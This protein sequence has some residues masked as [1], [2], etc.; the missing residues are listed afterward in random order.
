M[1]AKKDEVGEWWSVG[2]A[3]GYR[4]LNAA[5]RTRNFVLTKLP[6]WLFHV[7]ME[8]GSVSTDIKTGC[9]VTL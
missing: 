9:L 8:C 1:P 2:F 7:M 5:I 4:V 3:V 6:E